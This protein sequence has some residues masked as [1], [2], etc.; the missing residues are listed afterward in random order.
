[1]GGTKMR[2]SV[3]TTIALVGAIRISRERGLTVYAILDL[4]LVHVV[5]IDIDLAAF[6]MAFRGAIGDSR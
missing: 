5:N 2:P 6:E 4:F 1:M 3:G